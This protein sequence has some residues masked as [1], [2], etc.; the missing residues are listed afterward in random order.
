MQPLFMSA[1]LLA[2][3]VFCDNLT[4]INLANFQLAY[5]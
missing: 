3:L 1:V 5:D 2:H 4:K